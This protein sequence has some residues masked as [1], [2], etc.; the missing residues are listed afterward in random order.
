MKIIWINFLHFYQP[1]TADNETVIEAVEKSYKRIISALKRNSS[2]KFTINI[3]GCLLDKIA[4]LGYDNLINDINSLVAKKQIELV[5]SA[6]FHPILAFLPDEE[7]QRQIEI[8][9]QI[10]KKHFGNNFQQQGFFIPEATYNSRVAKIIKK[11]NYQ[12]LI[13]DEIS[14]AGKLNQVDS[15]ILYFD[16]NSDL[17]IVFRDR[18]FSKDYV[19]TTIL[20]L[21]EDQKDKTI[22]T[23]T[24]GELYGLRY[25]DFKASFEK[26]LK[27]SEIST[28][29]ISQYLEKLENKQTITL[30]NSSWESTEKELKEG[31]PYQLWFN[32]KNNIQIKLWQLANLAIAINNK[33]KNDSNFFWSRKHLDRGLASCTF[34]WASAH[35]FKLFSSI[36]W[37]PDEIEK[38]VNELIRSI[39][40][41]VDLKTKQEKIKAEKLY[42]KIK[43]LIWQ[44]HWRYYWR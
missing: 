27:R 13:L 22:I 25:I 23:A 42:I 20:K 36:S 1:P 43:H 18:I 29:T 3:S 16:K 34:W 40:S 32:K 31:L 4:S 44:K 12:W 19:P 37:N 17:K 26:L 35:D 38:G 11:N 9:E 39:R 33:Y 7:I 28:I 5:G 6:A 15:S 24:D 14:L 21:I 8:N 30:V 41:L 2:I 10:L